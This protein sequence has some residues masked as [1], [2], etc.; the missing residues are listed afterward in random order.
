MRVWRNELGTWVEENVP[1]SERHPFLAEGYD[2]SPFMAL[3]NTS[4]VAKG[5]SAAVHEASEYLLYPASRIV[6]LVNARTQ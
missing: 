5:M 6:A 2:R 1:V 3:G 4:P